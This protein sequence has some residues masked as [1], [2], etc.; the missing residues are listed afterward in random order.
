MEAVAGV[1]D[2]NLSTFLEEFMPQTRL[3][4]TG[5]HHCVRNKQPTKDS[6][7]LNGYVRKTVLASLMSTQ[8]KLE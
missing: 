4:V 8:H 6:T 7:E 1:G 3:G 2:K 5:K